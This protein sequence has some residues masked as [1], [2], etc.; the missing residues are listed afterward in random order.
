[1]SLSIGGSRP[2]ADGGILCNVLSLNGYS[3]FPFLRFV[4]PS[5]KAQNLATQACT[6]HHRGLNTACCLLD[7]QS[8][9]PVLL[10]PPLPSKPLSS[11][12][13]SR[14]SAAFFYLLVAFT[15]F[16]A[17]MPGGTP[18]VT[19]TV[20]PAPSPTTIPASQ[21][22]TGD[23][24]CCNSV[25]S[26]SSDAVGLLLGLLGIVLTDLNVLV[27]ITCSP[28][29]I[30]GVGGN[31]CTAQPVCCSNNNFNGVIAIGCTPVNIN[32]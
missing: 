22:N 3:C 1:M 13:F 26:A 12:M 8:N 7:L 11:K 23:L 21:C 31:S 29:S 4:R 15:V 27:G 25:E 9:N 30:I 24:Q 17:A 6:D 10:K 2:A 19:V 14:I 32:L 18:T 28:L 16:A 5:Y 20:T